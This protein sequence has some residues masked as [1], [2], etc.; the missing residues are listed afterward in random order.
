MLY[1]SELLKRLIALIKIGKIDES[2][3]SIAKVYNESSRND[4][5]RAAE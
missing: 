4:E 1:C 3:V 5:S 2:S